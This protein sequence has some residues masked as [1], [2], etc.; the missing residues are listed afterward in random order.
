MPLGYIFGN[1][2]AVKKNFELVVV[3]IVLLSIVPMIVEVIKERK[4]HK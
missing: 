3:A 1:I 2:P 4:A